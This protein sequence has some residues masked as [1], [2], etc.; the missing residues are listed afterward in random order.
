MNCEGASFDKVATNLEEFYFRKYYE[1]EDF[2]LIKKLINFLYNFLVNSWL[3]VFCLS[4]QVSVDV[5]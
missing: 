1:K 3:T 5:E 4:P 2:F